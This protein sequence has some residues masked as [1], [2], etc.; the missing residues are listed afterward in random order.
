MLAVQHR[1]AI[2]HWYILQLQAAEL[3][4]SSSTSGQDVPNVSSI[5]FTLP[6]TTLT[7]AMAPANTLG[8]KTGVKTLFDADHILFFLITNSNYVSLKSQTNVPAVCRWRAGQHEGGV[9]HLSLGGRRLDLLHPVFR[10]FA[11]TLPVF[12]VSHLL[13][14]SLFF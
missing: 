4:Q 6:P 14:S 9:W 8:S 3:L 7:S 13:P 5:F 12:Q 1:T 11:H 10:A 2:N